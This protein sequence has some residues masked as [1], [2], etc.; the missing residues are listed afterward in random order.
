MI[1]GLTSLAH[2]RIDNNPMELG[3][4]ASRNW[5]ETNPDLCTAYA[6]I[7]LSYTKPVVK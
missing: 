7:A 3:E 6:L 1:G 4:R 5:Q 2:G